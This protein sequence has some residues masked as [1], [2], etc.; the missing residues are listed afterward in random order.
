[1]PHLEAAEI[2]RRVFRRRRAGDLYSPASGL[3]LPD[4]QQP[5][6]HDAN[7]CGTSSAIRS[8]GSSGW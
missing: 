3:P 7:A 5:V 6:R 4:G 1:M 2:Q 8:S